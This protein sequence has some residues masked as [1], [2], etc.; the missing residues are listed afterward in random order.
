VFLVR[1]IGDRLE[2]LGVAM[3][4]TDILGRTGVLAGKA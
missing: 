3:R 2:K 4:S 1:R